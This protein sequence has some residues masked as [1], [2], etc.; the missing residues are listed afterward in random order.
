MALVSKHWTPR[1][2]TVE[3]RSS[4]IRRDPVRLVENPSQVTRTA[5]RSREQEM[6]GGVIGVLLMAMTLLTVIVGVSIATI[7]HDDPEADA[8]AGQFGQCYSGGS[9]CVVDGSTIYVG[10]NMIE[11]AGVDTPAIQDARCP[12]ERERGIDTATR[13]AELLNSGSVTVGGAFRDP[14]GRWVQKVQVN[15]EDIGDKM[16][17]IGLA[18]PYYGNNQ[19]WC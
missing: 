2:K 16:I 8:R 15:G 6:W 9:N 3:L 14:Y 4:R 18:R 11:I 13:L 17:A 19:G 12:K 1:K 10:G 7:L 5:V